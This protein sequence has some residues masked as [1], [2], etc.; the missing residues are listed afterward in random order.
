MNMKIRAT[1]CRGFITRMRPETE[2]EEDLVLMN[3]GDEC[4]DADAVPYYMK[5]QDD[6]YHEVYHIYVVLPDMKVYELASNAGYGRK[7]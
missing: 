5:G 3:E 7:S 6:K 1:V 4:V 2:W